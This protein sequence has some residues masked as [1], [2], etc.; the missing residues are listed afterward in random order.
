MAVALL[1]LVASFNFRSASDIDCSFLSRIQHCVYV[2]CIYVHI[3]FRWKRSFI[4]NFLYSWVLSETPLWQSHSAGDVLVI[5][6]LLG[7]LHVSELVE[8]IRLLE[9]V[10]DL[11]TQVYMWRPKW[12]TQKMVL[13][14]VLILHTTSN[15]DSGY[16]SKRVW[17][18]WF[19]SL[20]YFILWSY[21]DI[22]V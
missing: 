9:D 19:F 5:K 18:D 14:A 17:D 8:S 11:A 1:A 4:P 21:F 10:G 13:A 22:C 12:S 2:G 20:R 15:S 6:L 16:I 3:E 7:L